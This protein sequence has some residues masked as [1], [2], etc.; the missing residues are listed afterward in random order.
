MNAPTPTLR[1]TDQYLMG[2]Y[3]RLPLTLVRGKGAHVW[4]DKGNKYLDCIAGIAVDNLGHCHPEVVSALRRQAGRLIHVSNLFHI[5][6]QA[7]LARQLVRHSFADRVFFCNSG[8]EA[9]EAAIKLARRFALSRGPAGRY[10]IVATHRSFHG[11]TL[12]AL[13]ATG[14]KKMQTGF[15]PL[16]PGFRFVPFDDLPAMERAITDRTCAVLVE[17]IQGETG[18]I[19]P[20]RTYLKKLK[21]LCRRKKVLLILDEVQT[22]MGRTGHLFAHQGMDLEPD[23]MTLAKGLGGG[24]PIGA[25]LTRNEIAR[26]FTPGTHGCTFGG[27]PLVCAA[28]LAALKIVARKPFLKQVRALGDYLAAELHR[29]AGRQPA[30]KAIRGEGLMI[31]VDLTLPS[32]EV[33]RRCLEQGVLVNAIPPHTLRFVPPLIITRKDIRKL[34]GVLENSLNQVAAAQPA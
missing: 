31:G 10:E 4:D 3:Q 11:R 29:L 34:L 20:S 28:G 24:A 30:L 5:E 32:P 1:L 18:V 22:G 23:I 16:V 6:P 8:A 33:A 15:G 21:A 13:S 12:G 17:P 7:Q 2:N 27:N 14:Q 9:N 25:L 19:T 26:A